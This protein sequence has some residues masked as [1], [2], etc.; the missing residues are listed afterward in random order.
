M[1]GHE[2]IR[3]GVLGDLAVHQRN[4]VSV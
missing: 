4:F 1:S 3:A 2:K